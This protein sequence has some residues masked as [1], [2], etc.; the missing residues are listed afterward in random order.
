MR[1]R[2]AEALKTLNDTQQKILILKYFKGFENGEIADRLGIR[3]GNV[4]I[5][6]MRARGKLRDYC[7]EHNIR[8]EK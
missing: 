3:P 1:S 5:Q 6:A 2:L 7:E 8:W 4:R